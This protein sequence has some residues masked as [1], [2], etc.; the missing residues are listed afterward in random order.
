MSVY[1]YHR[2]MVK[3]DEDIFK[4]VANNS[5]SMR[6]AC[7]KLHM[8]YTTFKRHAIRLGVYKPN[9]GK[10]GQTKPN[11]KYIKKSDVLDVLNG[12]VTRNWT[13]YQLKNYMLK[14]GIVENRCDV[15]GITS[16][17]G[18]PL[19]MELHHVDGCPSNNKRENLLLLCPNCHAQT[20]NYRSKNLSARRESVDVELRKFKETLTG[21]AD[22]N[23][24]P[25]P[26]GKVQRLDTE[27]LSTETYMTK[28]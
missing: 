9:Q 20:E 17:N 22:G 13:A 10:K 24:E 4:F 27:G 3:I 15:C 28:E 19:N 16:W 18:H 5:D 14:F 7:L 11:V 26:K 21:N 1:Y 2:D 8:Q 6:E 25:S 12:V 23:L